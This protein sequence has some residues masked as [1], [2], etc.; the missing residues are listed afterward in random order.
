M[1][2]Y[3]VLYHNSD[4]AAPTMIRKK[5][6]SLGFK[7][8][9]WLHDYEYVWDKSATTEDCLTLAD[10]IQKTLDGMNVIF[11]LETI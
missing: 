2:T 6:F 7:P 8:I 3:L 4:G 11:K 9:R 10:K 5:L 1:K